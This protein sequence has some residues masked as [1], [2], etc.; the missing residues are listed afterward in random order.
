MA[1]LLNHKVHQKV[2][3]VN[4]DLQQDINLKLLQY[5]FQQ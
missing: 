2:E 5:N 4:E 1:L 3:K